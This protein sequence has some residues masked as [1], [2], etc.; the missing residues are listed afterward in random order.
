MLASSSAK[1]RVF[2]L[3][4]SDSDVNLLKATTAGIAANNPIPVATKASDMPGATALIVAWVA[5]DNPWNEVM[6]PHTVP[7]NPIYGLTDPTFAK[8]DKCLLISSSS[9]AIETLIDLLILSKSNS[10]DNCD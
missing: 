10:V 2:W 1:I 4:D 5:S 3:I 7:S 9:E 8:K 6:I